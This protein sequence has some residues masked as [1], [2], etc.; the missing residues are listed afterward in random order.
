MKALPSSD[1]RA[2]RYMLE[3]DDFASVSGEYPG[4]IDLIDKHTWKSIVALPDDV[5]I[6]TSDKYGPQ[7]GQMW[8]FWGMW[9]RVVGGIQHLTKNDEDFPTA[10]AACD[11]TD[12]FQAG[13]YAVLV[14]Y[15]RVAYSCLRNVLE[16]VTIATQLALSSN[17]NDIEAWKAAEERIKLGWAADLLPRTPLINAL[18]KHLQTTIGDTLFSQSPKGFVRRLF[19]QFSK[20]TH[21]A[22]GFADADLRQSNGPIFLPKTFL[23]WCVAALKTYSIA[24]HE[25][26]LAHPGLKKLPWGPPSLTLN[27]FRHQ[28]IACIPSNDQDLPILK[29]LAD[30]VK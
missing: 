26:K 14:G 2:M 20:Y 23:D 13:T 8:K 28:V 1:F 7:L 30:F 29:A 27:E 6:R 18:E 21:G 4:P 15:Y 25:L 24:L 22:S 9:P 12:E 11:S 17:A 3:D 19:V 5:S 10:I 16:R